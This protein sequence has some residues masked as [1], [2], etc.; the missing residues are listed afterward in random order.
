MLVTEHIAVYGLML[1]TLGRISTGKLFG[2]NIFRMWWKSI[3]R[4]NKINGTLGQW[5][6]L[7]YK[8]SY[9]QAL[10]F[11]YLGYCYKI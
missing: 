4:E 2:W 11:N 8:N 1:I 10:E 3:C 9:E 7:N 6:G 5:N